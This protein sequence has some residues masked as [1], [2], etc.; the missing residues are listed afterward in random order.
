MLRIDETIYNDDKIICKNIRT[1]GLLGRGFASQNILNVLRN[2]VE[3]IIIKVIFPIQDV[4]P[5]DYAQVRQPAI[6]EIKKR[7][8]QFSFLVKFYD[9]LEIS[10]SHYSQ[11]ENVAERLM[12]KYYEYL[13]NIKNYMFDHFGMVLLD[14]LIDFPLNQDSILSDYYKEIAERIE[15]P[16]NDATVIFN[17]SL[18]YY[19]LKSKPFFVENKVYYEIT[20][21]VANDNVSKFDR[22]IGFSKYDIPDNYAVSF[23]ELLKDMISVFDVDLEILIIQQWQVSIRPCEFRN[24]SKIFAVDFNFTGT[25][26]ECQNILQYLKDE[27]TDLCYILREYEENDFIEFRQQVSKNAQKTVFLDVLSRCREIIRKEKPGSNVISYMLFFMRNSLIK[28]QY[29]HEPCQYLSDLNLKFGC[30]PFDKM[31]F[32]MSLIDHNPPIHFL[33]RSIPSKNHEEEMAARLIKTNTETKGMLFTKQDNIKGFENPEALF[34]KFNSRLYHKHRESGIEKIDDSFYIKEYTSNCLFILEKLKKLSAGGIR[35]YTASVDFWLSSGSYNIDSEE[36]KAVLRLLFEKSRVGLI[37]GAAGTGKTTL[38]KHIS[39]FFSQL[40]KIYLANTNPA[41]DNLKRKVTTKNSEFYTIAS[42][43]AL[44]EKQKQCDVLFVDECSTVSNIDMRNILDKVPF[45]LLV[46]VGDVYQIQSIR[47]GNW[48]SLAKSFVKDSAFELVNPF[49]S[50]KESLL[51]VWEKVRSFKDMQE[52]IDINDF[53]SELDS[54]IFIPQSTDEIILCLN[55]NGLYGIN[56]INHLFQCRN[57]SK[58]EVRIGI[59]IYKVGDPILFNE[60]N[61]FSPLIYNNMK[62][63]ILDIKEEAQSVWFTIGL[64]ISINDLDANGYDFE[65]LDAIS[66]Q[67]GA[68]IRFNV[69]KRIDTDND[70]NSVSSVLPFQI[71]YAVSIHKAQ[72]LE[73]DSVKIIIT[74]ETEEQIT[75]NIFY[76]AITRSRKEL[77]IYWSPETEK[78]VLE[79]MVKRDDNENLK[80][81]YRVLKESGADL[82]WWQM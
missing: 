59:N 12:L 23:P 7:R 32:Y 39:D 46:L 18:R 71:A 52:A 11:S 82:S 1:L 77:K 10:A 54:S 30:I 49:R 63:H 56:N 16:C 5:R 60:S 28:K 15:K 51:D 9:L 2:F 41:I 81:L 35:G 76:T 14:N 24:L 21:C 45:Q 33:L 31:P 17:T 40:K 13:L 64:E 47:F 34:K 37:Y 44:D 61:R 58:K 6:R 36:K 78:A 48:F 62:G 72:G 67:G 27:N 29:H 79:S 70:T 75:H 80:Y 43:L 3:D 50:K 26:K 73:Y 19:V 55:Y 65:L 69:D 20:F 53:S 68:V 57:N 74:K 22:I 25:T 66:P 4:N 42:F 8:S 38:I